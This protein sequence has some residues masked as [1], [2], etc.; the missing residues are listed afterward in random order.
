MMGLKLSTKKTTISTMVVPEN[1]PAIAKYLSQFSP[2][3]SLPHK[4]ARKKGPKKGSINIRPCSRR[5]HHD[6]RRGFHRNLRDRFRILRGYRRS[7]YDP[8]R[9]ADVVQIC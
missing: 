3:E 8:H 1:C 2:A 4:A 5:I 9:L 6:L 7:S